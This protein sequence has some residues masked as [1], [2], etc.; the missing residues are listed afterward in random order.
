MIAVHG[1]H[2]AERPWC[3][4]E[5]RQFQYPLKERCTTEHPGSAE[6]Y[7]VPPLVVLQ[8]MTGRRVA[9]T[10]PELGYSPCLRWNEGSERLIVST[11]LREILLGLFYRRLVH[12][13]IHHKVHD[14]ILVN[15]APDPVLAQHLLTAYAKKSGKE[16]LRILYPGYG[17]SQLEKAGLEATFPK[18]HF[19]P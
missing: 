10:I 2:Y 18:V 8:N 5:I 1:D 9:R 15:R 19:Q 11:P 16:E 12:S 14:S 6:A 3:R 13:Y 17:L 7:F 4:R